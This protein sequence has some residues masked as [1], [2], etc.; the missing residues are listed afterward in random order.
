MWQSYLKLNMIEILSA[1]AKLELNFYSKN[2][3]PKFLSTTQL[4]FSS[5]KTFPLTPN[6]QRLQK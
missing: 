6:V 1:M 2:T 5:Q 3:K 4:F